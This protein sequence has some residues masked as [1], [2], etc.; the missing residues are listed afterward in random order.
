MNRYFLFAI[1]AIIIGVILIV[2][3]FS[4]QLANAKTIKK[5]QFTQT[6]TSTQDP[7]KVIVLNRW[8]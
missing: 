5:I 4:D 2:P 3:L 1:I 6:I 7:V 8:Q